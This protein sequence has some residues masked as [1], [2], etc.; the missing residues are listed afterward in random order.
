MVL[1]LILQ[2]F[3]KFISSSAYQKTLRL[4][5]AFFLG[6]AALFLVALS[7]G[8]SLQTSFYVLTRQEQLTL[9]ESLICLFIIPVFFLISASVCDDM[10]DLVF[11][12]M[13]KPPFIRLRAHLATA[14]SNRD[15]GIF[16]LN[17]INSLII[18]FGLE[19][20]PLFIG[21]MYIYQVGSFTMTNFLTGYLFGGIVFS[22]FISIYY[23]LCHIINSSKESSQ[24]NFYDYWRALES[25]ETSKGFLSSFKIKIVGFQTEEHDKEVKKPKRQLGLICLTAALS[26]ILVSSLLA[27]FNSEN[28]L[29]SVFIIGISLVFFSLSLKFYFPKFL[30]LSFNFLVCVYIIISISLTYFTINKAN[31]FGVKAQTVLKVL[32]NNKNSQINKFSEFQSSYPI[33]K[34][35]WDNNTVQDKQGYLSV[36]DLLH[37]SSIIYNYREGLENDFNQINNSYQELFKNTNVGSV[38]IEKLDPKEK[39]S[40]SVIIFFPKLKIRVMAIRGTLISSELLYDLNVFSFIQTLNLF[41][42]I[43]P[44]IGLLPDTV[45]QQITKYVD[46]KRLLGKEDMIEKVYKVASR[47]RE[48]SKEAG[49]EFIITGHSLGGAITAILSSKLNVPGLAFSPPGTKSVLKRFGI[50]DQSQTLKNLT[51]VIMDRD[52]VS[53]VDEHIGSVNQLSCSYNETKLCHDPHAILCEIYSSCGDHRK[54][55]LTYGCSEEEIRSVIKEYRK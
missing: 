54:R 33:C 36:L 9:L 29:I 52:L 17:K 19:V 10:L 42:V 5:G 47:E 13:N 21:V 46:I 7:L 48:R 22:F 24:D 51:T 34:M 27:S 38:I 45:V 41:D 2:F 40:R 31:L 3:L 20:F 53:M 26:M 43:T 32:E 15:N 49:D 4:R 16:K 14:F 1:K 18:I 12:S 8:F 55:S 11:D 50:D 39:F 25:F 30:G 28:I 44:V 23:L 6:I 37:L 35:R